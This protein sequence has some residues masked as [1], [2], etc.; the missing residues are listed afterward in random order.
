[1]TLFVKICGLATGADVETAVAAGADAVG[2][3]FAESVRRVLPA[4]AA[5]AVR[6][7]PSGILRVAV[8][9]HP[10]GAEWRSV[11]DGFGPDV[12]QTDA[13]D[14]E[15]LEIPD[16]VVTW[17]VYREGGAA[18]PD[19]LAGTWLYEGPAS[20][21]GLTVDWTRAA[22]LAARGRMILAGGLT[23]D[24]VGTAVA[25]VAP[26]GVDVSSGVEVAPGRKDP[27]L[28]H[29]FIRAARAAERS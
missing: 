27:A 17:P 3:V 21:R 28:V 15:T 8:M 1:M 5:G 24:N 22:A 11:L 9:H 4:D 29:Q 18:P 12:L 10:T 2:F 13:E 26:W 23:P 14:F 7:A 16:S 25:R 20:G 19:R 6:L